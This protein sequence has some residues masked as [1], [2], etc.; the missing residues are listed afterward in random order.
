VN[1][2]EHYRI[3]EEL[4]GYG[5][6]GNTG[7]ACARKFDQRDRALIAAAQVRA[8][9]AAGEQPATHGHGRRRATTR[10]GVG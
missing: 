6:P 2:I 4:L 1:G 9:L 7:E 5:G 3:G 8:T 10:D